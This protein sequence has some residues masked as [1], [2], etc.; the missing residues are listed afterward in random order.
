MASEKEE[1][2]AWRRFRACLRDSLEGLTLAA[3]VTEPNQ[4]KFVDAVVGKAK[5]MD[6]TLDN[7]KN[8]LDNVALAKKVTDQL[9]EL[10]AAL[11]PRAVAP[12]APDVR[13]VAPGAPK[14]PG[15]EASAVVNK[16][17]KA[18]GARPTQ[19]GAV[20]VD[21]RAT[22]GK[23]AGDKEGQDIEAPADED[24]KPAAR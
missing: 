16:P 9:K 6:K 21:Q 19:V 23:T 2:A 14:K 17:P 11:E 5:L 1:P 7:P 4:K 3:T 13:P 10:E 22:D 24:E 20:S 12:K 15:R 8:T 18:T